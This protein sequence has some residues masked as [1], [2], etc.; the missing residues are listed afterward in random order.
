MIVSECKVKLRPMEKSC[1]A[2][3]ILNYL[4]KKWTL[5]LLKELCTLEAVRFSELA[6]NMSPISPRTLSK[7]LKELEKLGL[8]ARKK[9]NEIPP[10]VEYS[11]T[12]H[13]RELIKCFKYLDR[14]V[15]K[16]G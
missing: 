3:R 9:F 5:H 14:W 8:V 16:F 1:P 10:R 7:R 11:L 13:G 12:G 15:K 6:G 2:T 4:G